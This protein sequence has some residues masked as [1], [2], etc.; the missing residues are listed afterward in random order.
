M[1]NRT[2]HVSGNR[3]TNRIIHIYGNDLFGI[4]FKSAPTFGIGQTGLSQSEPIN[5]IRYLAWIWLGMP[6]R[7]TQA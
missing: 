2:T 6:S 7:Q 5:G 4:M 3:I 1:L